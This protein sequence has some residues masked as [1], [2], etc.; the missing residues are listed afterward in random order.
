M[1]QF[2]APEEAKTYKE[3]VALFRSRNPGVDFKDA[4]KAR[5]GD[6]KVYYDDCWKQPEAEQ[7]HQI[8]Q[9]H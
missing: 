1:I 6:H 8:Y 7:I 9:Q 3:F 5:G 4:C 2:P